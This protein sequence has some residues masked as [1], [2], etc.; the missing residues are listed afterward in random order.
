MKVGVFGAYSA[1]GMLFKHNGIDVPIAFCQNVRNSDIFG[2]EVFA[3][4]LV[5]GALSK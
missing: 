2:L 3:R 5:R 1:A 4:R